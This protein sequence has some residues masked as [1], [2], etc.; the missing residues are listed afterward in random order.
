M[1]QL[2]I[3]SYSPKEAQKAY[4]NLLRYVSNPEHCLC[5]LYGMTNVYMD[6][7]VSL[8]ETVDQYYW[9]LRYFHCLSNGRYALHF[10]IEFSPS[11]SKHLNPQ[12][13][14][15]LGYHFA[16]RNLPNQVCFFAVHDHSCYKSDPDQ[17]FYHIDMLVLT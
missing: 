13:V 5:G 12:T 9:S 1:P 8:A 7:G 14:L 15:E 10:I 16:Q 4:Y 2:Q 11:E 3:V 6:L 17:I